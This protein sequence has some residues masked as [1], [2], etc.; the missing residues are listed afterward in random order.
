MSGMRKTFEI[1]EKL[2]KLAR[3]RSGAA[4]DAET[5]RLALKMLVREEAYQYMRNYLGSE[6]DAVD[7][8]RRREKP[9]TK[10]RVA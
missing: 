6:P 9:A 7:V 4:S 5:V 1:D 2:L 8:P 3:K 10:R